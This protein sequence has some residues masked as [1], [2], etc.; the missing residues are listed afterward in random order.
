MGARGSFARRSHY[1]SEHD[2]HARLNNNCTGVLASD[3]SDE[4]GLAGFSSIQFQLVCKSLEVASP[5]RP[6][7]GNLRIRCLPGQ[8]VQTLNFFR[9]LFVWLFGW[10]SS[11]HCL[12]VCFCP[13]SLI[14]TVFR[15]VGLGSVGFGWVWLGWVGL[16]SVRFG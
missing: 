5:V 15:T 14:Q 7:V 16:G 1:S 6:P 8:G 9:F 10:F 13:E 2:G 11:V 4:T 12:F 3:G